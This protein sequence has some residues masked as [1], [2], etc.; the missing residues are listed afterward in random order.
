M[1]L[2]KETETET[3][4]LNVSQFYI[5]Y[6]YLGNELYISFQIITHIATEDI[7]FWEEQFTIYKGEK[8]KTSYW[9]K[10]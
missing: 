4:N 10:I 8:N 6:I 5:R 9:P 3:D 7:L 1:P 2:N